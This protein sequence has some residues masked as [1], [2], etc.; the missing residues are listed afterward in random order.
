MSRRHQAHHLCALLCA[1]GSALLALPAAAQAPPALGLDA[2]FER[3]LA[4]SPQVGATSVGERIAREE[5]RR[6]EGRY[7]PGLTVE[8]GLEDGATPQVGPRGAVVFVNAQS[9]T[10]QAALTYAAVWGMQASAGVLMTRAVRDT[11]FFGNFGTAW[12][13]N[14]SLSLTQPWMRGFG[15]QIGRA[16][17]R[18]AQAGVALAKVELEQA[19]TALRQQVRQ[20]YWRLWAAQQEAEVARQVLEVAQQAL[21]QGQARVDVGLRAGAELIP[22]RTEIAGAKERLVQAQGEQRAAQI[23]LASLLGEPESES[24]YTPPDPPEVEPLPGDMFALAK[25]QSLELR[26]IELESSR[27]QVSRELAEDQA[28]IGLETVARLDMYGL[29]RSAGGAFGALGEL[30]SVVGYLGVRLE[31]P[32]W[33]ENLQAEVQ[34]AQFTSEQLRYLSQNAWLE[35]EASLGRQKVAFEVASQRVQLARETVAL[36]RQSTEEARAR[37]EAGSATALELLQVVAQERE[38]TL[39]LIRAQ[40]DLVLSRIEVEGLIGGIT[41]P[42]APAA[43]GPASIP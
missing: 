20:A 31:W 26:R 35:L 1:A 14:V 5:E 8:T 37:F 7:V 24:L 10:T 40:L 11:A 25:G 27:A 9:W 6:E 19:K 4:N 23:T 28:R 43:T 38:A 15:P 16:S 33:D 22:L 30:N 17:L 32:L 18:Q 29:A 13:T 2:A 12:N 3:A 34:R 21:I 39:R 36:A 42:D 41:F